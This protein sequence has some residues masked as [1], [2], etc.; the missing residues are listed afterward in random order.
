MHRWLEFDILSVEIIKFLHTLLKQKECLSTPT[1]T[2]NFR[3]TS[4]HKQSSRLSKTINFSVIG[5]KK[6]ELL[7]MTKNGTFLHN[8]HKEKSVFV[9]YK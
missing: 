3:P 4:H 8:Q 1:I 7:M 5:I 6:L 2:E 9:K